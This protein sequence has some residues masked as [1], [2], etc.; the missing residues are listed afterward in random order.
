MNLARAAACVLLGTWAVS[1]WPQEPEARPQSPTANAPKDI[2]IVAA[3][4]TE[5]PLSL[6]AVRQGST[7]QARWNGHEVSVTPLPAVL[8]AAGIPAEAKIR[9][10]SASQELVLQTGSAERPDPKDYAVVFNRRGSPVLAAIA[11]LRPLSANGSAPQPSPLPS[12]FVREIKRFDRI[13][14]VR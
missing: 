8:A 10:A 3:D 9:V 6:E 4:G 1:A 11:I 14:V 7:G 2:R 13:E 12:G 5:H